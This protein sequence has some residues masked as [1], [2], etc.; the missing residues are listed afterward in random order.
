MTEELQ[1]RE[2]VRAQPGL[3]D[4]VVSAGLPI[5]RGVSVKTIRA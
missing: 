5:G 4:P 3:T 2:Q 1:K